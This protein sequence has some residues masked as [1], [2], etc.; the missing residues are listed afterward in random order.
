MVR[1]KSSCLD[2]HQLSVHDCAFSR[3]NKDARPVRV[4]NKVC[5]R[6]DT[7]KGAEQQSQTQPKD[8]RVPDDDSGANRSRKQQGACVADGASTSGPRAKAATMAAAAACV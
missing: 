5:N 4:C 8:G 2:Q 3:R 7:K 6:K 1:P